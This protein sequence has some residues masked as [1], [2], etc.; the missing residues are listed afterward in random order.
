M[1]RCTLC[2]KKAVAGSNVSHSQVHTKRRF[3]PNL[4]KV[5]GLLLCT[6]CLRTIKKVA[7]KETASVAE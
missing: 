4:Q 7:G 2:D 1:A 3:K 6:Q 5:S